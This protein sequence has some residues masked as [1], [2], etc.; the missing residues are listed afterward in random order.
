[1]LMMIKAIMKVI[2]G[3]G[4]DDDDDKVNYDGK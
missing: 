1:M 3:D 4:D 2:S